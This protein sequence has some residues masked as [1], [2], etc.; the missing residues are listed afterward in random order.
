MHRGGGM[1]LLFL[2]WRLRGRKLG[3]ALLLQGCGIG[4]LYLTVYAAARFYN[5]LPYGFSF[6]V[7]FCLVVLSGILAV[8]QDAR[9]L[10]VSGAVGGF[11]APV[12]MSTGTGSHV[13]LFSYYA[14][15]NLGI[16]GIAWRKAWR[17]LNLVGFVFTFVIASVWGGRYYHPRY[18]SSTEP[19]LVLFF[20]Y[21]AAVSVLYALRLPGQQRGYV[22]GTLVFGLPIVAFGLQYGLVRNFEYGLAVSALCLGLFYILLATVLSRRRVEGSRMITESFLAFGI[23]F[24]SLAIPL[25]LDGRWTSAAWAIEGSALLWIGARQHRILP[26]IFG[27]LLQLGAGLS[28]RV[29]MEMDPSFSELPMANGFFV[30]CILISLAGLF[31]SWNLSK[32]AGSLRGEE[33][34]L[35]IPFMLW[36]LCWWFGAA[37]H[38]IHRF[39]AMRD[40]AA[41]GLIHAAV[42]FVCMDLIA[43][44]LSWKEFAYPSL[45]LLPAMA[46]ACFFSPGGGHL[47]ARFGAVA[48]CVAF[49][50]QYR[51]LFKCEKSWP[52]MLLAMWHACTLWVLIYLL[53]REAAYLVSLLGGART[54]GYCVWGLVP[55]IAVLALIKAGERIPWPVRR[56]RGEYLGAGPAFLLACLLGWTFFMNF[57]SGDPS[58][59]RYV[60]V[61]N[62]VEL[63]QIYLL[64]L[65]V[66]GMARLK[67]PLGRFNIH[68]PETEAKMVLGGLGFLLLNAM[69][70]RTIHFWWD[71]PYTGDGLYRSVL[72]QASISI[73]WGVTALVTTLGAARKGSRRVW[74]VGASILFLVV[75]KLFIVDLS[76]VGTVARI[77]SFLGV[78]SLML[79]IGYF[80]PLPPARSK[81]DS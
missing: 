7:M 73:L 59:L 58:P 64:L 63:V 47:M 60:P 67:G 30:G 45:A 32:S 46:A 16:V 66:E 52:A 37:F 14:L 29:A 40:W 25:A 41:I 57:H 49:L 74:L 78:G 23:V 26:R 65:G 62:P 13:M 24:G 31:S 68:L 70:A 12:L 71:V 61:L 6:V 54:W 10:A 75:I 81:E 21:Y 76:R 20:L 18:F 72:F 80:S 44:R 50:A 42:S 34:Q 17:E 1:A 3:Y 11:L 39:A 51:L 2:G 77:V 27:V 38:E 19:F 15:L 9:S 69:V 53:T 22:D 55:G 43:R 33:R 36:G 35:A 56:F 4:I 79:L 8:L 28:F 5:L 48:W